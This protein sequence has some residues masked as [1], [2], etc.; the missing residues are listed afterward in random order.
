MNLLYPHVGMCVH[1]SSHVVLAAGLLANALCGSCRSRT[2]RW[3]SLVPEYLVSPQRLP[4]HAMHPG[5]IPRCFGSM[6]QKQVFQ[7][8]IFV[9]CFLDI[10]QELRTDNATAAEDHRD[11]AVFQ[12]PAVFIGCGASVRSLERRIRFYLR[13]ALYARSR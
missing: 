13:T 4:L 5:R 2:T 11:V 9:V 12:I 3:R 6:D 10:L 7:G 8:C 1:R